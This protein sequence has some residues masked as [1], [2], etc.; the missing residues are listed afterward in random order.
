MHCHWKK[1]NTYV[2]FGGKWFNCDENEN[3]CNF[4]LN[5]FPNLTCC[6]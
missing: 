5:R 1:K 4:L 2:N 6:R 3:N